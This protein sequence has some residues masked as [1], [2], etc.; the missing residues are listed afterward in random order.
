VSL[1]DGILVGSRSGHNRRNGRF[2]RGN[3]VY[4]TRQ[5]LLKEAL[6]ALHGAYVLKTPADQLIAALAA[7]HIVSAA[8]ARRTVRRTAESRCA[9]RL[10]SRLQP[11]PQPKPTIDELLGH[12]EPANG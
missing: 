11:K 5:K 1:Q 8:K 12:S 4:Q 9:D 7:V 3:D 10:L 2:T 6:A